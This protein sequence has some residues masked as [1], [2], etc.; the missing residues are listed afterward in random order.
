[1]KAVRV[2]EQTVDVQGEGVG[3]ELAVEAGAEAIEGVGMVLLD[4]EEGGELAVDG[5]DDL[6]PAG[7][8]RGESRWELDALVLARHSQ[9][10]DAVG[11]QEVVGDRGAQ[12]ALVPDDQ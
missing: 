9:Q 3:G 12:I 6:A 5:L 10:R 11:G 2:P 4:V 8:E 7:L 1:M